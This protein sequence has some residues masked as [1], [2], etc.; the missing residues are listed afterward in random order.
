[1]LD[2]GQGWNLTFLY[3]IFSAKTLESNT[4]LEQDTRQNSKKSIL[5]IVFR[6]NVLVCPVKIDLSPFLVIFSHDFV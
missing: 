4:E 3:F 1:M 5:T 2:V 6:E